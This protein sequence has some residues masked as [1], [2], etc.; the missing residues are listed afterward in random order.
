[1]KSRKKSM[2]WRRWRSIRLI[3]G[4]A[5]IY[6]HDRD[7]A[8]PYDLAT[9]WDSRGALFGVTQ[10]DF[11]LVVIDSSLD[12]L[13]LRASRRIGQE[14]Y[15]RHHDH[16]CGLPRRA[17]HGAAR[18]RSADQ[19]RAPFGFHISGDTGGL[20]FTALFFFVSESRFEHRH[21]AD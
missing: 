21:G 2:R 1:M 14:R 16:S 18:S 20:V 4:Y 3:P 6:R 9:S 15:V 7:A 10:A 5:E 8:V 11:T 17:F 12:A 13:Y 19:P